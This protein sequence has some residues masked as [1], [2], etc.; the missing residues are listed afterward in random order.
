MPP[1]EPCNSRSA[2]CRLERRLG[3]SL[4]A[5][6]AAIKLEEQRVNEGKITRVSA[7]RA[8]FRLPPRERRREDPPQDLSRQT[9]ARRTT[10]FNLGGPFGI[11]REQVFSIQCAHNVH[12]AVA[13]APSKSTGARR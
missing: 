3:A 2:P 5:L 9:P 10:F 7:K 1:T 6:T 4:Y 12:V 11:M 13:N 8:R